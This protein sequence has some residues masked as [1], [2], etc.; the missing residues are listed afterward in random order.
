M[1]K[2][3]KSNKLLVLFTSKI[4]FYCELFNDREFGFIILLIILHI[5]RCKD[6]PTFV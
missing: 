4:T 5:S 1:N 2:K 6:C 3:G